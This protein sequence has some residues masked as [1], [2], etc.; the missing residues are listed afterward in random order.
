MSTLQS[1]KPRVSVRTVTD[2][3]LDLSDNT[4]KLHRLLSSLFVIERS[5][6]TGTGRPDLQGSNNM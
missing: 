5:T 6:F 3:F 1:S 4:T 2:L